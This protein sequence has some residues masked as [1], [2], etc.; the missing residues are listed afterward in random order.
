MPYTIAG[1]PA[2]LRMFVL[3]NL[4]SLVSFAYSSM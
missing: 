2:R 4:V 3:M 1:T